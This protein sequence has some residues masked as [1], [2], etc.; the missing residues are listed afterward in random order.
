MTRYTSRIQED[1]SRS[2]YAIVLKWPVGNVLT[3]GSPIISPYTKVSMLGYDVL[4]WSANV[5]QG[6]NVV[7]PNLTPNFNLP[8]AWVLK[9]EN[10]SN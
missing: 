6:I 2:V 3:L 5:P 4:D 7:F 8:W 9:M 1:Q 10:L